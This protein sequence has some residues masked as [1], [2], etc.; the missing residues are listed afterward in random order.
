MGKL[1]P[2]FWPGAHDEKALKSEAKA[3]R[4][5]KVT[6]LLTWLQCYGTYISVMAS[7]HPSRV[8]ELMAYMITII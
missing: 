5:R 8:P 2:E 4:G 1:L 6:D 7:A 3:H